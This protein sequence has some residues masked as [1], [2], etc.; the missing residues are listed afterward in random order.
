[1]NP[2]IYGH[3]WMQQKVRFRGQNVS[4]SLAQCQPEETEVK[5]EV[6][7]SEDPGRFQ[8]YAA[9]ATLHGVRYL[10]DPSVGRRR[11]VV[12][13]VLLFLLAAFF[14]LVISLRFLKF[15]E[16]PVSR[17]SQVVVVDEMELPAVTVCNLNMLKKSFMEEDSFMGNVFLA[18]D[19]LTESESN[20]NLSDPE[21][22]A[23]VDEYDL[24]EVFQ[25]GA[26]TLDEMLSYCTYQSIPVNC[27]TYFTQVLTGMGFCYTLN[28]R[29]FIAKNG[30]VKVSRSGIQYGFSV[31]INVNQDEYFVQSGDSAG[32]Q[33]L[34]HDPNE[35]PLVESH[36]MVLSPGVEAY[37]AISKTQIK[38]LPPPYGFNNSCVDTA[39][40][41]FVN[42]LKYF[43]PYSMSACSQNCYLAFI[44]DVKGCGCVPYN[45][46]AG[47]ER[48]KEC[49]CR[50]ACER[51]LFSVTKSE[52][53]YPSE[54]KRELLSRKLNV[55]D[56]AMFKRNY[57]RMNVFVPDLS[58][59]LFEEVPSYTL[60]DF[61][62]IGI[63]ETHVKL[64][65]SLEPGRPKMGK[66]AFWAKVGRSRDM[67]TLNL[68]LFSPCMT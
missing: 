19:S 34:V 67:S 55:T 68:S 27:S 46:A 57:L 38:R 12:W 1:M 64:G 23:R 17:R 41:D 43:E 60:G 50:D 32:V 2:H 51:N 36:G 39:S 40:P 62:A 21:V 7:P 15:K 11:R 66:F 44:V 42:P 33:V 25:K 47:G 58:Y 13:G 53:S 4:I 59:L 10:G 45:L 24:K 9:N 31:A 6:T 35:Y 30:G 5:A 22:K 8:T 65:L 48:E 14:S 28:A 56:S 61:Q 3:K 37:L 16:R 18:T 54:R 20:V 29:E 52:S 49:D 26:F 63:G